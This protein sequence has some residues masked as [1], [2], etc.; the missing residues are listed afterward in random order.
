[1]PIEKQTPTQQ[2]EHAC[3][4]ITRAIQYAVFTT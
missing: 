2:L 1:M 4:S 3:A